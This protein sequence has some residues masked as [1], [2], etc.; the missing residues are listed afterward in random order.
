MSSRSLLSARGGN[1]DASHFSEPPGVAGTRT[2]AAHGFAV[3]L[4]SAGIGPRLPTDSP[5][6]PCHCS[7]LRSTAGHGH[8]ASRCTPPDRIS[9]SANDGSPGGSLP[10]PMTGLDALHLLR[11]T[12]TGRRLPWPEG[13]VLFR[14]SGL[15][16]RIFSPPRPPHLARTRATMILPSPHTRTAVTANIPRFLTAANI[17]R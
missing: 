3:P 1:P 5:A 7:R 2:A 9:H 15:P 4:R 16:L 17:S 12:A 14:H 8:S 6:S 13:E 11:D 10:W